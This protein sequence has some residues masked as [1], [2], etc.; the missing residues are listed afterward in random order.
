MFISIFKD[1]QITQFTRKGVTWNTPLN[2]IVG[3]S[4]Y[5]LGTFENKNIKKILKHIKKD[6]IVIDIGANVGAFT[7]GILKKYPKINQVVCYEPEKRNFNN[8][9]KNI[10]EN[11]FDSKTQILVMVILVK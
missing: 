4:L 6:T 10:T 8:L 7:I 9:K 5:L 1:I 11:N 3:L 2:D